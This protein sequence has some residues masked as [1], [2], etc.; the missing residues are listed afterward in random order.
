MKF[1]MTNVKKTI[2]NKMEHLHIAHKNL[3]KV[4]SQSFDDQ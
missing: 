1:A 2:L 3:E 4:K